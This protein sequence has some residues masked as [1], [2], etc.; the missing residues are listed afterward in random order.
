M[1]LFELVGHHFIYTKFEIWILNT[2]FIDLKDG[3]MVLDYFKKIDEFCL[4]YFNNNFEIASK[5]V[6]KLFFCQFV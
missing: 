6:Y 5:T 3:V 4:L 1:D 2:L